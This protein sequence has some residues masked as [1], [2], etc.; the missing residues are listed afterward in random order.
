MRF[1]IYINIVSLATSCLSLLV[2]IYSLS[3]TSYL[4]L[5]TPP[6][7]PPRAVWNMDCDSI[8]LDVLIKQWES[9]LQTSNGNFHTSAWTEAEKALAKTEMHTG[10]APKSVSCCQNCWAALK[11]DYASVKKLKEMSGF[12]W[13]DTKRAVTAPNEVWDKLL[14]KHPKLGKWRS[15]GFPLFDDMADLVD[16]TYAM[17]TNVYRP[18]HDNTPEK[19]DSGSSDDDGQPLTQ[20][21]DPT[22]ANN[23]EQHL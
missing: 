19:S 7:M 21:I 2:F 12:G 3:L 6:K 22:L 8:L 20:S 5:I 14:E 9:G 18:G 1:L 15:K 23:S 11:K 10:G 4:F 16:G 17:G 13:D